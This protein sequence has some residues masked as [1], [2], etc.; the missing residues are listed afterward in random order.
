MTKRNVIRRPANAN[1]S[2]R[3]LARGRRITSR[4]EKMTTERQVRAAVRRLSLRDH[5]AAALVLDP[6]RTVAA[7]RRALRDRT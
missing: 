5:V 3:L 7:L 2:T 4:L 1:P 6:K